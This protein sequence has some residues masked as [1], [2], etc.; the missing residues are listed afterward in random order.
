MKEP[1]ELEEVLQHDVAMKS[2]FSEHHVH[3]LQQGLTP[4]ADEGLIYCQNLFCYYYDCNY[5]NNYY[6][7]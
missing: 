5:N 4:V 3:S 1:A 2:E 7:Y 6:Y